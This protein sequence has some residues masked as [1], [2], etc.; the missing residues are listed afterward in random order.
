MDVQRY[1]LAQLL[2]DGIVIR[3]LGIYKNCND[4]TSQKQVC[5][6]SSNKNTVPH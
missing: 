1:I 4:D 2:H 3:M 5:A 6:L